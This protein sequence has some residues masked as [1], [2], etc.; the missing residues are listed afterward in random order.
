MKSEEFKWLALLLHLS[1]SCFYFIFSPKQSN[2]VNHFKLKQYGLFVFNVD[3]PSMADGH[4]CT[5]DKWQQ[6]SEELTNSSPSSPL[7]LTP[8]RLA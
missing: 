6:L 5:V 3:L 2:R 1:C 7:L 8:C 4:T